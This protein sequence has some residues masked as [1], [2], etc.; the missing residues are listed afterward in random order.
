MKKS[1]ITTRQAV[2]I[3][4]IPLAKMHEV[5]RHIS[6]SG[7]S[8]RE[9][10]GNTVRNVTGDPY[11]GILEGEVFDPSPWA[12]AFVRYFVR[13]ELT[14]LLP[15]KCKVAFA[16]YP[17]ERAL[18]AIHDIAFES[19]INENGEKGFRV[20]VG[21]GTSIFPRLAPELFEFVTLDEYLKVSEA[22]L[23]IFDRCDELRVN[24]ARARIKVYI[25]R[26]G[27]DAFREEVLEE[28][29]QPWALE[30]DFD[31]EP[32]LF[33]PDEEGLAP[34]APESPLEP[35]RRPHGI[36]RL[37]RAQ[38]QAAEAGGLQRSHASRSTAAT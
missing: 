37:P 33:V 31:P 27:M 21:G 28:M 1:H 32:L 13:N 30:G 3:H 38:R 5:L 24:R 12:G 14:Q 11:A 26:I 16:G 7:L 23:R 25:D 20:L 8:S 22:V 4:H 6:V 36:Q 9:G 15:R 18:T 35:E 29:K 2:Q 10:C 19:R 17:D 34:E